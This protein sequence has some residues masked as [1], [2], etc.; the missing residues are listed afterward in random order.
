MCWTGV[1]PPGWPT[2]PRTSRQAVSRSST[3]CA[4]SEVSWTH[5]NGLSFITGWRFLWCFC[6]T[7]TMSC[8]CCHFTALFGISSLWWL[9]LLGANNK[10]SLP[11]T[12]M[13][14]KQASACTYDKRG[15][16]IHPLFISPSLT[17][18]GWRP[19]SLFCSL[20]HVSWTNIGPCIFCPFG[21]LK[22][23]KKQKHPC[24]VWGEL[25]PFFPDY[26]SIN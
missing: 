24:V 12:I 13:L 10:G 23:A 20:K 1:S 25:A 19:H 6:I 8:S 3:L 9:I 18:V 16:R 4:C 21:T 17:E 5:S 22:W 7:S 26:V 2:L 15:P 11:T 14:G